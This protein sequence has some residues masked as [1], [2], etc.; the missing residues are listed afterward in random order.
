MFCNCCR[1]CFGI[2]VGRFPRNLPFLNGCGC[3]RSD[4][5]CGCDRDS[6]CGCCR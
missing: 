5:G 6:D 3:D 2:G 1:G 4:D